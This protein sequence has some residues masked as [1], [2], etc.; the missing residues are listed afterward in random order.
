MQRFVLSFGKTAVSR[1]TGS[2]LARIAVLLSLCLI[3]SVAMQAQVTMVSVSPTSGSFPAGQAL[4]FSVTGVS[5]SYW[6]SA[7]DYIIL[8]VSNGGTPWNNACNVQYQPLTN[9]VYLTLD[10]GNQWASGTPGSGGVLS[11]SQCSVNVSGAAVVRSGPGNPSMG[12]Y[13]VVTIYLPVTFKPG[14]TGVK[15]VYGAVA[16]P[17]YPNNFIWTMPGSLTIY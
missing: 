2:T 15:S 9:I 3:L 16:G 5:L 14:W 4:N 8:E 12:L 10:S 7:N 17:S 13:E 6:Q 1:L 11:N